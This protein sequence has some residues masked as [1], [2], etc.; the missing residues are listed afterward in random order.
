MTIPPEKTKDVPM[1]GQDSTDAAGRPRSPRPISGVGLLVPLHFSLSGDTSVVSEGAA[2]GIRSAEGVAWR[3][4][5]TR[6]CLEV[7]ERRAALNHNLP[8]TID[9][10]PLL[11]HSLRVTLV[12]ETSPGGVPSQTLTLCGA[13][14]RVWL[15]AR[16]G[17]VRGVVHAIGG[18]EVHAALSQRLD[19]PLVVGTRELQGLVNPGGH[20][21]LP[22]PRGAIVVQLVARVSSD[23]AAYVLAEDGIFTG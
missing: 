3:A 10:S 13:L 5:S 7:P 23:T 1:H 14:G 11:G 17:P 19:G 6:L 9:L 16:L 2:G 15:I 18:A 21:R 20:V 22:G 8:A 4:D 12:E